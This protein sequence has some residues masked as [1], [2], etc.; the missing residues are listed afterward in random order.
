MLSDVNQ[1]TEIEL[2]IPFSSVRKR[3]TVAFFQKE[4]N[5]VRLIVKGAPEYIIPLCTKQLSDIGI[6]NDFND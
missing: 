4:A 6:P 2:K 5:V 3:M 1:D